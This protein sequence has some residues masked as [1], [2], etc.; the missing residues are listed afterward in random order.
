[1]RRCSCLKADLACSVFCKC[2]T[3]SDVLCGNPLNKTIDDA[4]EN[5]N[6]SDQDDEDNI[7]LKNN[8]ILVLRNMHV[9]CG[10]CLHNLVVVLNTLLVLLFLSLHSIACICCFVRLS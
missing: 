5:E 4:I 9:Y 3:R 1:M 7:W 10:I 8:K 6:E 2:H